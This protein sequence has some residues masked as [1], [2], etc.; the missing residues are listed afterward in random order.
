MRRLFHS[1][2]VAGAVLV[3]AFATQA[4]NASTVNFEFSGYGS[5]AS[6]TLDV[7]GGVVQ[8]GSGTIS[9]PY[10]NNTLTLVTLATPGVTDAGGGTFS[11]R[12]GGGT[13]LIGDNILPLTGNGLVF[14][15]NTPDYPGLDLG[16]NI[17]GNPDGS[18]TGFLAGNGVYTSFPIQATFT[19]VAAVPEAS[20][21]AML[22]LGFAGI[23]FMAYRKRGTTQLRFA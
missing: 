10:A 12:F 3:S 7:V 5:S 17:W 14:I 8:S 13:D 2:L 22:I 9:A 20:T 4:A 11:Y 1:A 15:V 19:T 21:W 18:F 6:G 23:G 16:F